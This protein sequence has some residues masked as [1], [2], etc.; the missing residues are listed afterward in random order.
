VFTVAE[1][2]RQLKLS[3]ACVYSLCATGRLKH[4]RLG[5]GR[6]TIRVTEEQ[7]TEFLEGTA[8]RKRE[9]VPSSPQVKGG[10]FKYL[11]SSRLL[12]AWQRQG[13]VAD[14]QDA[15]SAPSSESSRDP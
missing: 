6:G 14:P 10:G 5:L 12:S 7:F 2:A 8:V 9:A 3:P 13:V 1:I 15:D 4:H 11:D